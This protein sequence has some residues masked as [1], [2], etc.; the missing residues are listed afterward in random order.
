[1]VLYFIFSIPF[2]GQVWLY[3]LICLLS[4][5]SGS[6][7][8]IFIGMILSTEVKALYTGAFLSNILLL[9]GGIVWPTESMRK[10]YQIVASILPNYLPTQSLRSVIVRGVGIEHPLVWPGILVSVVWTI[11]LVILSVIF[12]R[13]KA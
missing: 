7:L 12:Y 2:N 8:G 5:L 4:G 3:V 6:A 10:V 13:R 9:Y 11:V 1:M